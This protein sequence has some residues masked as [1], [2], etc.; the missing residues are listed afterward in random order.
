MIN[1]TFEFN[2]IE[3]AR[4]FLN[5]RFPGS[6]TLT[7]GDAVK[8]PLTK[9]AKRTMPPAT[10]PVENAA[11]P[12]S[13]VT[14]ADKVQGTPVEGGTNASSAKAAPKAPNNPVQA[15]AAV[16]ADAVRLAL[17]EVFNK[18]GA[19]AATDLLKE[20]GA[21]RISDVKPEQFTAFIKA[22]QK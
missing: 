13:P 16:N 2:T 3:E 19:K 22:C 12:V 15:V 10:A 11:P 18:S 7:P 14:S 21:A 8:V 20:F 17:R 4:D 6:K 9:A 5:I 1:L